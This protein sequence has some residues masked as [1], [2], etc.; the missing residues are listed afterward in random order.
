MPSG[1]FFVD[2]SSHFFFLRSQK[3]IS[4]QF[5]LRA[6]ET[7]SGKNTP[8]KYSWKKKPPEKYT[9]KKFRKYIAQRKQKKKKSGGILSGGI[10]SAYQ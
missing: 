1:I 2:R 6:S 7:Y 9:E 3:A 10:F 5:C 4:E 8:E